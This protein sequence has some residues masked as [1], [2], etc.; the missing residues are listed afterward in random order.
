LEEYTSSHTVRTSKW[1][2]DDQETSE[3][4]L[5][6]IATPATLKGRHTESSALSFTRGD[7]RIVLWE[8]GDE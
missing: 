2:V 4:F 6:N 3:M 1:A 8:G 7:N 5:L